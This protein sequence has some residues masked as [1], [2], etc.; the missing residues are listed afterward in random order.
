MNSGHK[1]SL[2]LL[3]SLLMGCD[4]VSDVDSY[5]AE[6]RARPPA[7]IEPLPE[8]KPF[9]PMTYKAG[10]ERSPFIQPQPEQGSALA[11]VKPEC[12]RE[13]QDRA[14]EMLEQ[15]G[16][17]NLAMTGTMGLKGQLWALVTT[18]DGQVVKVGLDQHM[19]LNNGRVIRISRNALDL[20]ETV[21]DGKG[22]WVTRDTRLA[23]AGTN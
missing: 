4:G 2:L 12:R 6:V 10:E 16:L 19:G 5:I 22:C 13:E 17:E 9:V 23:M 7:P 8:V 15:Y 3:A 20:I 18:P 1:V 14:K 11:E 21:P